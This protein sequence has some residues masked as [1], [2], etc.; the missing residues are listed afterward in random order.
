M[1]LTQGELVKGD[2]AYVVHLFA[3]GEFKT[4]C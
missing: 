2:L 3:P 4:L 1:T